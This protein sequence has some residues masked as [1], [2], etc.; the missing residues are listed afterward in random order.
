MRGNFSALL[1][2]RI[3]SG[4]T[5]LRQHL[6]TANANTTY[7]SKTVHN[8]LINVCKEI[9]QENI[10]AEGREAKLFSI[11]FD[12]TTDISHTEQLSLSFRYF[13]KECFVTFC[14]AYENYEM[15]SCEDVNTSNE[16]R[17]IGIALAHIV[18]D[19]CHKF[20]IDLTW[21]VGIG[22]DSCSVMASDT[23][24]AVYELSKK[25]TDAKR[26]PCSNHVLNNSLARSSKVSSCRNTSATM[27]KV[28]A[29]ANA[30]AKRHKVFSEELGGTAMQG[31]CETRWIERH[32]GHL[33]FQGDNLVKICN[34]LENISSWEDSKTASD[35]QCLLKAISSPEFIIYI[36]H[37]FK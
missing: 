18:E 3:K 17:L 16:R 35:A 28:V 15:I 10:L 8:E 6:E 19:L 13:F 36:I 21:C 34:A 20:N 26:C 29:F 7:I 4:D 32:D 22:T 9:I 14:D 24:G 23:K 27:K 5:A 11:M 37:L 25:S 2:F 1:K 12:E 33:Q 31:I 30:S